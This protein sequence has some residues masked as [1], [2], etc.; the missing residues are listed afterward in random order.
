MKINQF[1]T[2]RSAEIPIGTEFETD[3]MNKIYIERV[4]ENALNVLLEKSKDEN[5]SITDF[6][7]KQAEKVL[8]HVLKLETKLKKIQEMKSDIDQYAPYELD[9]ARI[10]SRYIRKELMAY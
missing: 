4:K 10:S 1:K 9:E 8:I 3:L 6:K 5:K 7:K 2:N